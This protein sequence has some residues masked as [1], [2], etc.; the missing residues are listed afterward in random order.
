MGKFKFDPKTV[1]MEF[2]FNVTACSTT[3][4]VGEKGTSKHLFEAAL[5]VVTANETC[6]AKRDKT[7]EEK[8]E[9]AKAGHKLNDLKKEAEAKEAAALGIGPIVPST[10]GIP[11]SITGSGSPPG[12][13]PPPSG[14]NPPPSGS[15]PTST[16]GSG[17]GTR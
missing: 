13:A 6:K 5:G 2:I 3:P 9:I 1:A 11:P 17:S 4:M 12:S 10:P 7:F 15:G 16:S 8:E 14:S